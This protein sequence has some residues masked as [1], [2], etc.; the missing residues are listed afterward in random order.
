MVVEKKL[1]K[2][3]ADSEMVEDSQE[4][5]KLDI[6]QIEQTYNVVID[7]EKI[8]SVC[9]KILE[10]IL[11]WYD[12]NIEEIENVCNFAKEFDLEISDEVYKFYTNTVIKAINKQD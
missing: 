11:G 2:I 10:E 7:K 6:A 1:I 9:K 12:K 8:K 3:D 5:K 4:I